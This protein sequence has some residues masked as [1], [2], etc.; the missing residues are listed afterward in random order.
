M[1]LRVIRETVPMGQQE[2][3]AEPEISKHC[4]A[5]K[6][7]PDDHRLSQKASPDPHRL[8]STKRHLQVKKNKSLQVRVIRNNKH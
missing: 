4:Q 8:R 3:R 6:A 1:T 7:I 2:G 5:L